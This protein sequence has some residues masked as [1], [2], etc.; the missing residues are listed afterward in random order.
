MTDRAKR[1]SMLTPSP[2]LL[3]KLG[4]LIVHYQEWTSSG[5]HVVDRIAIDTLEAEPDVIEWID[6]MNAAGMLPVKRKI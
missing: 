6:A 2:T 3:V 5:A 1:A 4:S